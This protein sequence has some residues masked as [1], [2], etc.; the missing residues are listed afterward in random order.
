MRIVEVNLNDGSY[1]NVGTLP[2]P[3]TVMSRDGGASGRIGGQILWTF[4]DTIFERGR[5][6]IDGATFRTGTA[7]LAA[8]P[9]KPFSLIEPLDPQGAPFQFI[10]QFLAVGAG[11]DG[12]SKVLIYDAVT[13]A[14]RPTGLDRNFANFTSTV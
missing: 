1:R 4:G 5:T 3:P 6:A 11:P 12:S 13:Y 9:S 8:D 14:T 10:N 2:E 7:A